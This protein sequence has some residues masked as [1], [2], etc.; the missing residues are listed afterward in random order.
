MYTN[1]LV[2]VFRERFTDLCN[3][4]PMNDTEIAKKIGVSKQT[5]SAWK[6]GDRSPKQPTI[7]TIANV[8]HVN[9]DWLLGFDVPKSI[10]NYKNKKLTPEDE[11][12][13]ELISKIRE[14]T[15]EQVKALFDI[16]ASFQV[17]AEGSEHQNNQET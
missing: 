5:V 15:P 11:Q 8:F 2:T 12:K 13:Q 4:S 16:F 3:E 6:I 9:I 7:E 10:G 14:A 1:E 17:H